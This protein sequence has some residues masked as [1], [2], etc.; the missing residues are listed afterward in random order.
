MVLD[1]ETDRTEPTLPRRI[2]EGVAGLLQV[3]AAGR[4]LRLA[5]SHCLSL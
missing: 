2:L 4:Y 1:S 3:V 5:A